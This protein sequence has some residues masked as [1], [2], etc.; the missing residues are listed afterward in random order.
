[1]DFDTTAPAPPFATRLKDSAEKPNT[2][3]ARIVGFGKFK[4]ARLTRNGLLSKFKVT[5]PKTSLCN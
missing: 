3:E 5:Y 4:P 2:P 1:M